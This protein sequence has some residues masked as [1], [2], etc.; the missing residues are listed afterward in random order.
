MAKY[1]ESTSVSASQTR[2]EIEKTLSRYGATAFAYGTKDNVAQ[3]L[4]EL[5]NRQM[6]FVLPLPDPNAREFWYTPTRQAKRS[7]TDAIRA[8]NQAT[9]QRW[10]ALL[11][12]IKA[13]LEAVE[14]GISTVEQEFLNAILLPG[15]GTTVGEYVTPRLEEAYTTGDVPA[16]LPGLGDRDA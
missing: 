3:I 4:F 13:K 10:R 15:T 1:A 8:Y 9:K 11:L 2:M 16:L 14:A 12:V 7:Q 6:R 5:D